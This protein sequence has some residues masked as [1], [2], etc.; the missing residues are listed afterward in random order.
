MTS[1]RFNESQHS[2]WRL[3]HRTSDLISRCEE[4]TFAQKAGVSHQ[5]Y[6]IL[7]MMVALDG[8]VRAVDL[9]RQLERSTNTMS[10]ILD[11]MEKCGFV[12]K[13]RNL[14]DRRAVRLV[15]TQKGKD[16]L[17]QATETGWTLIHRLLASFSDR[18]LDS[19]S[20][21]LEKLRNSAIDELGEQ[22]LGKSLAQPDYRRV[23]R[24]AQKPAGLATARV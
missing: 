14:S 9:A 19:L 23:A 2:V 18:D 3:L 1:L 21:L 22:R 8:P 15:V 12:R 6:E 11:R 13:V 20:C 4:V 17:K 16:K 10:T 7:L 5:H 24:L